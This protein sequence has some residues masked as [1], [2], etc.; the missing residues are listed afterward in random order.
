MDKKEKRI[1]ITGASRGIGNAI[2]RTLIEEGYSVAACYHTSQSFIEPLQKL[3][4]AKG[5]N[6][7]LLQFDV[8]NRDAARAAL[9]EDITQHGAYYGV[10]CNAGITKDA[11][12]PGM[13]AEDWDSVLRTNLDSFYNIVH[14]VVMPMI[15]SR[16]PGRIIVVSSV[17]GVTGNRGQTNYSAAKAGLIGAAKSLAVELGKRNI[18]VN[19][20]AP[21]VIETDM[22]SQEIID[23]VKPMIALK[24]IGKPEEVAA[25]VSFFLSEQ[26]SYITKQV[27][28]VDGGMV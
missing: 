10:V 9:E 15:Q 5:V 13:S 19:C 23:Y 2:A 16:K 12:F 4:E 25:A 3:A 17:S 26:A 24:R 14:P 28:C 1:L 21:G 27:L 11:P 6:L 8:S 18:T 22:V 7:Q 20:I